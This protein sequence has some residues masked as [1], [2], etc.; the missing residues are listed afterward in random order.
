M[1]DP[2]SA[3]FDHLKVEQGLA[4]KLFSIL[5][6]EEESLI[7]NDLNQLEVITS[8]KSQLISEYLLTRDSRWNKLS[9]VD[10]NLKETE[11]D[12]WIHSQK[13]ESLHHIWANLNQI[14]TDSQQINRTNGLII[15]QLSSKNQRA[16]AILLGQD[17]SDGLYG[18]SGQSLSSSNFNKITGY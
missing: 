3:L 11:L 8:E 12:Q 9:L 4:E 1:N 2:I 13:N 7:K 18:S 17:D 16:M 15:H 6:R 10:I 5:K 14:L